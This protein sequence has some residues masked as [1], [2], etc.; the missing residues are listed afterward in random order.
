LFQDLLQQRSQT[1][2]SQEEL[3]TLHRRASAWYARHD[4]IEEAIRHA[5]L[6]RDSSRATQLVEA[7]FFQAFEQEQLALVE[8]WLHLL[9]DKQIQGSPLLLTAKAW[10]SQA[11]GQLKELPRLLTAADQLLANG[12]RGA[13]DA[14]DPPFRLLRGLMETLW[15]LYYFHPNQAHNGYYET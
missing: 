8:H 9:P 1:H 3:A 4:L 5:L 15:S 2:N 11:R 6:A 7:H 13:S 10:I 12:D 14:L